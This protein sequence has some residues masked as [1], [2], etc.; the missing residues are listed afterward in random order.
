MKKVEGSGCQ[1]ICFYVHSH[2]LLICTRLPIMKMVSIHLMI[3]DPHSCVWLQIIALG[4][5]GKAVL[6]IV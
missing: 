3:Y 1:L 4:N 5:I 2:E 6:L